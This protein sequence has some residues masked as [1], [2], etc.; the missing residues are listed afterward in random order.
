MER[1]ECSSRR[2]F[3][4]DKEIERLRPALGANAKQTPRAKTLAPIPIWQQRTNKLQNESWTWN[5]TVSCLNYG[6]DNFYRFLKENNTA[7]ISSPLSFLSTVSSQLSYFLTL[8]PHALTSL[9]VGIVFANASS[10]KSALFLPP[11]TTA[12]RRTWCES[13]LHGFQELSVWRHF[14]LPA[15]EKLN[16][17]IGQPSGELGKKDPRALYP[18]NRSTTT[19]LL[20]PHPP[21][22]HPSASVLKSSH[23]LPIVIQARIWQ[24]FLSPRGST[25]RTSYFRKVEMRT[26]LLFYPRGLSE[27]FFCCIHAKLLKPRSSW[28]SVSKEWSMAACLIYLLS[29]RLPTGMAQAWL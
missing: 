6:F 3:S 15:R 11:A 9:W 2:T 23:N 7:I 24:V 14:S 26:V 28:N 21:P 10:A 4:Q 20:P 19:V 8:F 5:S 17:Y 29:L 25:P 13:P 16:D 12:E 27:N 18:A 1:N 22:P